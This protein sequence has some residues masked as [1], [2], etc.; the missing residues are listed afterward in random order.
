M[1]IIMQTNTLNSV[2]NYIGILDR[3]DKNKNPSKGKKGTKKSVLNSLYSDVVKGHESEEIYNYQSLP[4][5]KNE[6]LN[7]STFNLQGY[8]RGWKPSKWNPQPE[9]PL[10]S[11]FDIVKG[12]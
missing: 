8:G 7:R 6:N 2:D 12:I 4:F 5:D 1:G 3:L 9:F 10:N 11:L